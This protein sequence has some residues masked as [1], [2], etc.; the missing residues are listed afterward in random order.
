MEKVVVDTYAL[1]AMVFGELT[2][3]ARRALL[4]VRHGS[5][6]GLMPST[7]AYEFFLQWLRG[8]IPSLTSE[9]E[10]EA[11]IFGYFRVIDLR[12]ADFIE[13]AKLKHRGDEALCRCGLEGRRLS[14]VDASVLYVALREK[15]P[16]VSGDKDLSCA[17]SELGVEV[18]W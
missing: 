11:F 2:E 10:V 7:V 5:A 9:T 4:S 1:M 17:A 15:A 8:R 16:I 12:A 6:E 18:L 3:R 14:L 13:I